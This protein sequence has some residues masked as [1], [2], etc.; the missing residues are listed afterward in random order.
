MKATGT[1]TREDTPPLSTTGTQAI[2]RAATLLSLVVH[3][4]EPLS[5]RELADETGLARST[6][7]RLLLALERQNLLERDGDGGFR[8][9]PLFS[10]YAV[11]H[12]PV[13]ALVRAAQPVLVR[14]A[15]RTGET[16]NFAVPQ[17]DGVTQVAQIDSTYMVS[18]TNW[19]G[20]DVPP[21]C[22]ALGKVM[23]AYGALP[24]PTGVLA[25]R[26]PHTIT[27]ATELAR[28][29]GEV[30]RRGYAVTSGELEEGLDAVGAPVRGRDGI[31]QAAIGV[32]GPSFRLD[33]S[34][35]QI[36]DLLVAETNA[37]SRDIGSAARRERAQ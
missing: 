21:H 15:E 18:T 24:M 5:S 30:R 35:A 23:Y 34:T 33:G 17:G 31:V 10:V 25:R 3:A 27:S 2:D 14:I 12:D 26:T 19:V 32:S 4:E 22:S 37:L 13:D 28:E 9:G 20:V 16:V 7:S 1:R 29:L 11:R 6:A 8:P 36:G